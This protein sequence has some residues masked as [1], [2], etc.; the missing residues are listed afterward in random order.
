MSHHSSNEIFDALS[1]RRGRARS[2][3]FSV[4]QD[5]D[6]FAAAISGIPAS[7]WEAKYLEKEDLLAF[8][9][10]ADLS[11][12]AAHEAWRTNLEVYTKE[13]LSSC[14]VREI[15]ES[16]TILTDTAVSDQVLKNPHKHRLP[17]DVK[18]LRAAIDEV[19]EPDCET[20]LT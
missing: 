19:K 14:P 5:S 7:L 4:N 9:R 13:A 11:L 18:L 20:T 1:V 17:Q 6:A 3:G 2:P 12:Q 10:L 15:L 8:G 16:P